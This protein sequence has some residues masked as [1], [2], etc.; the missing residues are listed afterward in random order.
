[1]KYLLGIDIGSSSVKCALIS[2]DSGACVGSAFSPSSE[3]QIASPQKGFAEQD[4]SLWWT[5]L[6]NAM[7]MLRKD[8]QFSKKKTS[9]A[10]CLSTD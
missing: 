6:A 7:N 5:E 3:M 1:M 10:G 2:V 9:Q 8:V 4:P